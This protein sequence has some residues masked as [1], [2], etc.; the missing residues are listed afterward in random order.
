MEN[1]KPKSRLEQIKESFGEAVGFSSKKKPEDR[2][3]GKSIRE[4][5]DEEE[6]ARKEEKD[7]KLSLSEKI[8]RGLRKLR[9]EEE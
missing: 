5:Y 9:G 8:S 3:K 7:S 4:I 2:Y 6:A 1:D